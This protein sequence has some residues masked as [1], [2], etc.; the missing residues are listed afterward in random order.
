MTAKESAAHQYKEVDVNTAN[1]IQ[2][3]VMLYNEAILSLQLARKHMEQKDIEGRSKALNHCLAVITE[4]Q[5]SL[6]LKE[7]GE[8][9]GSLD[10]LYDYMKRTI[11]KAHVDQSSAP[12]KEIEK[13]LENLGAAWKEVAGK[14]SD[15]SE[16]AVKQ[17]IHYSS[18]EI[19]GKASTTRMKSLNISI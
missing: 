15:G 2:L 14:S 12:L 1:P 19:S 17:K 6:N 11:F 5:S 3:V 8:I 18:T 4:L 13:L 9:A 16:V 7:G 10:R